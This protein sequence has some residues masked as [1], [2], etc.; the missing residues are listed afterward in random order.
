M[1]CGETPEKLTMSNKRKELYVFRTINQLRKG[2]Q[3]KDFLE[4]NTATETPILAT[5]AG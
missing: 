2:D 1:D 5:S 4:E 3:P